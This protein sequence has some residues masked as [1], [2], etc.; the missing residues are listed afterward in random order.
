MSQSKVKQFANEK[1]H[2]FLI[3]NWANTANRANRTNSA[4]KAN[5]VN[6]VNWGLYILSIYS[7]LRK[8]F[9]LFYNVERQHKM[10]KYC[11]LMTH[12]LIPVS[13]LI[14]VLYCGKVILHIF[15]HLHLQNK[16]NTFCLSILNFNVE[17]DLSII[18]REV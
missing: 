16:V 1:S 3:V 10:N 2:I 17:I 4:N 6:W 11:L 7:H 15:L 14:I 12:T 13:T 18:Q 8:L 9:G 5:S